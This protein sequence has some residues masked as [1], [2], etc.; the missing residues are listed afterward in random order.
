MASTWIDKRSATDGPRYRV[1]FRLGGAECVPRYGGS[2]RTQREAKI[3]RD[4]IAGEIAAPRHAKHIFANGKKSYPAVLTGWEADVLAAELAKPT[5]VGWY[6]NPTGGTASLAVPYKQSSKDRTLYPDFVFVHKIE[7][8]LVLDVAD[9]HRPNEA[10]T[11]AKWSGLAAYAAAHGSH[12]RSILAVIKNKNDQLVS[13]DLKNGDRA[14]H[15][16]GKRIRKGSH[17]GQ[18]QGRASGCS[19][20]GYEARSTTRD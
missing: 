13:L 2:F 18:D 16:S 10:D 20:Q 9:P 3:R 4:W 14:R 19:R 17:L 6:R 11:S 5:L 8:N 7:G 12:Y 15:R 1:R